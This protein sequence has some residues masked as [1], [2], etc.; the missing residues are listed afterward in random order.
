[1]GVDA[2]P[3]WKDTLKGTPFAGTFLNILANV[4]SYGTPLEDSVDFMA[5]D[6]EKGLESE[7]IGKRVSVKIKPKAG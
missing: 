2:P 1:M 5:A 6:L 3:A 7:L 4:P